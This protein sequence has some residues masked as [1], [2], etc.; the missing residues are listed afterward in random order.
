[1]KK[2]FSAVVISSLVAS[3]M[4]S[5]A[6]ASSFINAAAA[7]P[8]I[9]GNMGVTILND[10]TGSDSTDSVDLEYIPRF[11][12]TGAVGYDSLKGRVEVEIGYRTNGIDNFRMNGIN[13]P[14]SGDVT[15]KSV[16]VNGYYD[17]RNQTKWSTF[18]GAGAGVAQ[19]N[20]DADALLGDEDDTAFAYQFIAGI[21]YALSL[22]T[23]VDLS[24]RYF[25]TADLS[26]NGYDVDYGSH[27]IMIGARYLF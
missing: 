26:L 7:A 2:M 22:H 18:F 16:M 23:S 19:V 15:S 13:V 9:S 27:N 4:I 25:A 3:P 1:M 11:G 10:S 21:G 24:Y 14:I 20:F 17:F 12:I 5:H 8:Y 6:A